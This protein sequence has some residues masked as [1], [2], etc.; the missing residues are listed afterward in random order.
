MSR[1]RDIVHRLRDAS[2]D[3]DV[4]MTASIAVLLGEAADE[5]ARL[6]LTDAEREAVEWAVSAA[7]NVEHPAEAT[8]RGL[9]ER[10]A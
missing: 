2:N 7:R 5:L 6:R 10:M 9:L 1:Q 4:E 8:L 3:L